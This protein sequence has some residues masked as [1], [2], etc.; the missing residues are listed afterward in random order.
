[1]ILG[2]LESTFM[3]ITIHRAHYVE[4]LIKQ[5]ENSIIVMEKIQ[6]NE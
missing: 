5:H 1:M 2:V 6:M 4:E 3:R